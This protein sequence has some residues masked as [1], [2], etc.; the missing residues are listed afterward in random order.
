MARRHSGRA[1]KGSQHHLQNLVNDYSGRDLSTIIISNNHSLSAYAAG[2]PEWRSP[3]ASENY[4]EY[5][6]SGFLG[7]VK[8]SHLRFNLSE[9]WPRPGPY[10]DGLATVPG[11]KGGHG[12]ILVEAK[13]HFKELSDQSYTCGAQGK[14]LQR[15]KASLAIVKRF[16]AVNKD[17]DW[18]GRY[19]QYANRLAHLYWLNAEGVPVWMVFLHFIGDLEQ[20]GSSTDIEWR[21]K[22]SEMKLEMGLPKHHVLSDRIIELFEPVP[23]GHRARHELSR[24]T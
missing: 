15:I 1:V 7:L 12:V 24:C 5:M 18:L 20:D 8:L 16:L 9:F 22:L 23:Q 6:G 17:C 13:S 14:G 2:Q 11:E 10:W 19:Y 21:H 4:R 3:L